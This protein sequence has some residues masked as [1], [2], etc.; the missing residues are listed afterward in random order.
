MPNMIR[1][2]N[3]VKDKNELRF[4]MN[5]FTKKKVRWQLRHDAKNRYGL[6]IESQPKQPVDDTIPDRKIW[7]NKR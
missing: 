3:F 4:M 7:E 1:I 5:H 2:S 6:Y